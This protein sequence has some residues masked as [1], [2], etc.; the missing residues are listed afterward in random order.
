MEPEGMVHALEEIHRVTKPAGS[1][2]EIHPALE[3]PFIEVRW[4]E[5]PSFSENDPGFDW[6][7]DSR[8]AETA[9]ATVVRRGLFVLEE[10]RR[11]ELR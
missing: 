8:L 3:F 5:E 4:N 1:L 2:I 9:V 10:S 11:F 7:E 6:V